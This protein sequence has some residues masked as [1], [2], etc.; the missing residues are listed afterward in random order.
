MY[1]IKYLLCCCD[2]EKVLKTLRLMHQIVVKIILGYQKRHS[3]LFQLLSNQRIGFDIFS[4]SISYVIYVS[5]NH[6][7]DIHHCL[8]KMSFHGEARYIFV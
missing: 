1:K 5:V 6:H 3:R 8:M 2:S 7:L 4:E